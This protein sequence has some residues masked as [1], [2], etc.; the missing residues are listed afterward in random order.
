MAKLVQPNGLTV[1]ID[2]VSELVEWSRENVKRDGKQD[3]VESGALQLLVRDGFQGYAE[4][5]PYDAIHVGA[6]PEKI[7]QALLEQLKPGGILLLPVGPTGTPAVPGL[8][9]LRQQSARATPS[10]LRRATCCRR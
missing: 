10:A 5:G 6:A 9:L 2:H 4:A 3:L 7:P 1:G 8:K